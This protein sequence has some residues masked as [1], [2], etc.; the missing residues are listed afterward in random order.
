MN[1]KR[2]FKKVCKTEGCKDQSGN[3]D[4]TS[5]VNTEFADDTDI[6]GKTRDLAK[7][8]KTELRSSKK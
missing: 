5:A 3:M 6:L 1:N 8:R 4:D 7:T 2:I